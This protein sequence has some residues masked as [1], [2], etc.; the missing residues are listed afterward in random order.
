MINS[1]FN[2]IVKYASQQTILFH[3]VQDMEVM[4]KYPQII[5]CYSNFS[6]MV[7]SISVVTYVYH[8]LYLV[9]ALQT[10]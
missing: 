2:Q 3:K 1:L 5:N 8:L 9:T 4:K 7:V 10:F 6:L